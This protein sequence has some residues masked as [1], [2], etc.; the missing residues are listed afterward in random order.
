MPKDS[1]S[2]MSSKQTVF[3]QVTSFTVR[4]C[5]NILVH[6]TNI[7]HYQ[8]GCLNTLIKILFVVYVHALLLLLLKFGILFIS[9]YVFFGSLAII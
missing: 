1:N 3:R 6:T 5:S 7:C 4:Q 9:R 8:L 2:F